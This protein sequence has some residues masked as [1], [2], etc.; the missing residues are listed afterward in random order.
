[1]TTL[2]LVPLPLL[3]LLLPLLLPLLIPFIGVDKI[4]VPIH[5]TVL[6]SKSAAPMLDQN[7]TSKHGN[8]F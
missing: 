3:L 1:L 8:A 4:S 5:F 2:V 7:S 6:C